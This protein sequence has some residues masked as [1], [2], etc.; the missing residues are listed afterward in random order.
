MK[1]FLLAFFLIAVASGSISSK[2]FKLLGTIT[3]DYE[4]GL[5]IKFNIEQF[6][7]GLNS[8]LNVASTADVATCLLTVVP[9]VQTLGLELE[10]IL[11]LHWDHAFNLLDDL[12]FYAELFESKCQ[13]VH[14]DFENHFAGAIAA[15]KQDRKGFV[16][17]VL[18]N[19]KEDEVGS[20]SSAIEL[21]TFILQSEDDR[22]GEALGDL[23]N[24]AL[25]SYIP[26][27][28]IVV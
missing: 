16:D 27:S 21:V 17:Q 15:F 7:V 25:S 1:S 4:N 12:K 24:I 5:D 26:T 6:L 9:T 10:D 13:C 28:R 14:T 8:G 2:M 18:K 3:D 11:D 20:I 22:A 19:L 23:I